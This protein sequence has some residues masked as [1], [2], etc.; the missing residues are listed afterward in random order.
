[1][2]KFIE[3]RFQ[4]KEIRKICS[5]YKKGRSCRNIAK[6]YH[7]SYT[8][9]YNLLS[10]NHIQF[11]TQS[12]SHRKYH[13]NHHFFDKIDTEEKAY[14]LGFLAA[15]GNVNDS[16]ITSLVLQLRDKNHIKKF[17]KSLQSNYPVKEY[18]YPH[19]SFARISIRSNDI[20]KALTLHGVT[21]RK[22]FTL[23]WKNL[24]DTLA[25]HYIR[26]YFD[27]DGGFIVRR[28]T[29]LTK[30]INLGFTGTY[31]MLFGIDQ[32]LQRTL[33]VPPHPPKQQTANGTYRTRYSHRK[34]AEIIAKKFYQ[35]ATIY[36]DRKYETFHSF[37]DTFPSK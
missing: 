21:S 31:A 13:C 24:P 27:G 32:F 20:V 11:R 26:G 14:W 35:K 36:L 19:Q 15:D 1:M 23:K 5:S 33:N 29:P 8:G 3:S 30:T 10:R 9:I 28:P 17:A 7:C 25:I 4:K 16:G 12:E 34:W 18:H 22:T 37:I 6:T 2:P